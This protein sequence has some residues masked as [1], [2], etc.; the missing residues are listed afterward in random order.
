LAAAD[1]GSTKPFAFTLNGTALAVP[2]IILAILETH[3]QHDGSVLV[4]PPLQPYLGGKHV[5]L[6]MQ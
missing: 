2:R 3:Q 6:P 5:I 4:P 1:S